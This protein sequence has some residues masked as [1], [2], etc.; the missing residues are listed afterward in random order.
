L[1]GTDGP[2]TYKDDP[3][4]ADRVVIIFI[5]TGKSN[6]YDLGRGGWERK[7]YHDTG[8]VRRHII[9]YNGI[10]QKRIQNATAIRKKKKKT[11]SGNRKFVTRRGAAADSFT[12]DRGVRVPFYMFN[13][14][15]RDNV[16]ISYYYIVHAA[17]RHTV[18]VCV[19]IM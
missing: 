4:E 1:Q 18:C 15:A 16:I 11:A 14:R 8:R 10:R 19:H 9:F 3:Q 12:G 5:S 17:R 7:D 6:G 13:G 2:R